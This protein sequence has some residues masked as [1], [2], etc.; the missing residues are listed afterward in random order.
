MSE[1]FLHSLW[2]KLTI[3]FYPLNYT[4]ETKWTSSGHMFSQVSRVK[5]TKENGSLAFLGYNPVSFSRP[6]SHITFSWGPLVAYHSYVCLF[7]FN[8]S[9][10]GCFYCVIHS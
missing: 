8:S 5:R 1:C 9:N 7:L 4:I 6:N 10:D 2:S 3:W